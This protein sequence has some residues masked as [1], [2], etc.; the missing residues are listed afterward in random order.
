VQDARSVHFLAFPEVK[1][2]YL[3]TGIERRV[4]RMQSVIE[5]TR[6]IRERMALS[7]KV[8]DLQLSPALKSTF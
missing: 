1:A 4:K 3:D 5:L 2:E 7:L 8:R 6:A